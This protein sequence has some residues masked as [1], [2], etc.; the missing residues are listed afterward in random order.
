MTDAESYRLADQIATLLE[1]KQDERLKAIE[2]KLNHLSIL[3]ERRFNTPEKPSSSA[4][5][6]SRSESAFKGDTGQRQCKD[7]DGPII[8]MLTK[9]NKAI[10]CNPGPGVV[11]DGKFDP[12]THVH[13][14]D[15]CPYRTTNN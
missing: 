8:Y 9:S 2:Q 4:S 5:P 1:E 14:N 12:S 15:T 11:K 7:C 3:L 6:I 13:H 10:P